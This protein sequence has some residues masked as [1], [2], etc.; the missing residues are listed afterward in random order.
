MNIKIKTGMECKDRIHK[1][2]NIRQKMNRT[3]EIQFIYPLNIT[4]YRCIQLKAKV[5]RCVFSFLLKM[6]RSNHW[7]FIRGARE[8]YDLHCAAE[9]SAL[10]TCL[11]QERSWS[12]VLELAR[13]WINLDEIKSDWVKM[14]A[15]FIYRFSPKPEANG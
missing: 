6:F 15:L 10:F 8:M 1:L 13:Q 7:L 2:H 14:W 5:K 9:Q 12:L 3:A 4:L 11:V